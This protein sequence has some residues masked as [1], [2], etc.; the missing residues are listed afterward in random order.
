V[1]DLTDD[2]CAATRTR[3]QMISSS[4]LS[5]IV[6]S[7]ATEDSG[8]ILLRIHQF[9]EAEISLVVIEKQVNVGNLL[10]RSVQTAMAPA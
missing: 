3:A 5:R 7:V 2:E 10:S 4:R 1:S 9:K 8:S 6:M